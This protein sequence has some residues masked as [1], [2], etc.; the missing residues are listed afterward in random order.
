MLSTP[1]NLGE[2]KMR[3]NGNT[4]ILAFYILETRLCYEAQANQEFNK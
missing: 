3:P 2:F 4:E 1:V